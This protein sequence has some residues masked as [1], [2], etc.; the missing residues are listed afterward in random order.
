MKSPPSETKTPTPNFFMTVLE[1]CKSLKTSQCPQSH[2]RETSLFNGTLPNQFHSSQTSSFC[3]K[4]KSGK[5]KRRRRRGL[6]GFRV[7]LKEKCVKSDNLL[8]VLPRR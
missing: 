6:R 5:V 4:S 8:I 3:A 2:V 7:T 1:L